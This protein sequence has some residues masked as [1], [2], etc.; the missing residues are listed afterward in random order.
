MCYVAH[1]FSSLQWL[2]SDIWGLVGAYTYIAFTLTEVSGF[3]AKAVPGLLLL[4]GVGTF[5]GNLLGGRLADRALDRS[6][7]MILVVLIAV[8][9]SFV[10]MVTNTLAAL[11]AMF[12][13]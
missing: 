10:L 7:Q 3:E 8:L 13:L 9:S 1:R 4:F 11:V 12:L 6:L 2:D 5:I